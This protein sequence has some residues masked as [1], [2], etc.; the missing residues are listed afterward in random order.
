VPPPIGGGGGAATPPAGPSWI[1]RV[2]GGG[3]AANP[4]PD[5]GATPMNA[6]PPA[7]PGGG[8]GGPEAEAPPAPPTPAAA[9]ILLPQDL[10]FLGGLAGRL[11]DAR[12]AA[13]APHPA[14]GVGG[15]WDGTA[16]GEVSSALL[17]AAAACAGL[18]G[19][20]G[21]DWAGRDAREDGDARTAPA[22]P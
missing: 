10:P 3:A 18:Y 14:D 16:A 5:N 22:R 9:E 6:P 11:T 19:G 4:P 17:A 1:E 12:L 15:P 13:L 21:L 2:F 7:S 8:G 20:P